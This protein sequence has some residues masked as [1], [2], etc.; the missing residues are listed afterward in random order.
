MRTRSQKPEVRRWRSVFGGSF[1]PDAPPIFNFGR[2]WKAR[3]ATRV[4]SGQLGGEPLG[5]L[6]FGSKSWRRLALLPA[7]VHAFNS[8]S[9][10]VLLTSAF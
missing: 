4:Q 8:L 10:A 7:P 6:F 3:L 1:S 5:N 9:S 2:L